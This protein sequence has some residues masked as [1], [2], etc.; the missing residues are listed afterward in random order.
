M[1]ITGSSGVEAGGNNGDGGAGPVM[2]Q[3]SIPQ[4][5]FHNSNSSL[6]LSGSKPSG[7]VTKFKNFFKCVSLLK[8]I[9]LFDLFYRKTELQLFRTKNLAAKI[10][11]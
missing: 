3:I 6:N 10:K 9:K 4:F 5:L 2:P 11:K 8:E 1:C 7:A